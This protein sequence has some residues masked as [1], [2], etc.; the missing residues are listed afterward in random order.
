MY[1]TQYLYVRT[2][3][4]IPHYAVKHKYIRMY[5]VFTNLKKLMQ[6]SIRIILSLY[7]SLVAYLHQ[8]F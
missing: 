7:H 1:C 6:I 2:N 4:G 3:L 8:L 5:L